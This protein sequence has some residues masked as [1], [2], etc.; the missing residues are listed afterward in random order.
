MKKAQFTLEF[1]LLFL[2]AFM[3][4]LIL[5]TFVVKFVEHS[6]ERAEE[7]RLVTFAESVRN[8]IMIAYDSGEGFTVELDVPAIVDGTPINITMDDGADI[9][10]VMSRMTNKT[11]I[12]MLP[13]I[14]GE[15]EIGC[16]KIYKRD[17]VINIEDC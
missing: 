13:D 7:K 11:I 1:M 9:L 8:H 16:N 3:I 17:G 6:T 12:K 10:Y 2:V 15:L 14:S 5:L 4:F